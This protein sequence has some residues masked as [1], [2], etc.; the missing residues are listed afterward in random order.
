MPV[1]RSGLENDVKTMLEVHGMKIY[2]ALAVFACIV[3]GAASVLMGS[4][5][6]DEGWYLYAANLVAEGRM[7]YRDF[8]YT[9]GP[10]LPMVYSA[11]TGVWKT[12][13]LLGA[14]VFNLMVGLSGVVLAVALARRLA[15]EG[16]KSAAALIAFL[17][18][19]SNL[20]HLYYLAIPKTY[21]LAGLFVAAGFYLLAVA[22]SR[23]GVSG[24]LVACASGLLL[25]FASG[26]R[27]SLGALLAVVGLWLLMSGRWALLAGFCVGGFGGLAFVYGRFVIDPEAFHGL[28]AAQKY[29]AARGGFDPV[30]TVGSL[31]R[32]V[33]WYLPLFV[34]LGLAVANGIAG[35]VPR[36]VWLP[37]MAFMAVFGIQMLAPFPYEDY[38]V[39]VMCLLAA[40][41]AAGIVYDR[42]AAAPAGGVGTRLLAVLGMCFACS[43]GSPLL[44]KWTT[45]GQDRFWSIKK[46]STELAQLREVAKTIE[47]IDPGGTTILTQDLYIAI[48]TGRKVPE[49]LEMGPFAMMD[50]ENWRKLLTE[51]PSTCGVAA[52]SGYTFAVD[53]PVCGERPIESQLEYWGIV[54]R[55]Y[56]LV[57]R[58]ENFGQNATPLLVLK[59][60]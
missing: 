4:L 29:H 11:F 19:A 10:F 24:A 60:R 50:D 55:G 58:V 18:L 56:K 44:E 54:K 33:R 32:L 21:A 27:I 28:L 13:G 40:S 53:P 39:P 38:Q 6:Q 23:T 34:T 46:D 45:N 48:E 1:R 30:W 41:S 37:C 52:L 35:V 5:N 7:P 12:W 59:K 25:A 42:P 22:S 31:S 14:R 51:A 43:F 26:T 49:G 8:F 20:Y 9:Q 17:L 57:E 16:R 36:R 2:W 3:L 47:S 15:P